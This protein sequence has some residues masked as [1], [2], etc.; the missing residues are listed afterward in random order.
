MITDKVINMITQYAIFS[1]HDRLRIE[2]FIRILYC[3]V[4]MVCFHIQ[5]LIK[6]RLRNRTIIK[7]TRWNIKKINKK[8]RS[9]FVYNLVILMCEYVNLAL[10][11]LLFYNGLRIYQLL[12]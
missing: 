5:V 11:G 3:I 9:V 2:F 1:E 7:V 4:F 10:G 12:C 6:N 8:T